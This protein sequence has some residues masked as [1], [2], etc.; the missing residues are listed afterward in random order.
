MFCFIRMSCMFDEEVL[1]LADRAWWGECV[2]GDADR[3]RW[4]ETAAGDVDLAMHTS[5]EPIS[6]VLL[7]FSFPLLLLAFTFYANSSSISLSHCFPYTMSL[8]TEEEYVRLLPGTP[9][10]RRHPSL[11]LSPAAISYVLLRFSLPL[12][13][14]TLTFCVKSR[15]ISLS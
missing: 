9:I 6:Y 10:S 7:M 1:R 14:L 2:A 5:L 13:L 15:S 4:G 11:E 8:V 3:A 12:F